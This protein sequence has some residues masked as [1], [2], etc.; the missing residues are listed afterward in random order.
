MQNTTVY[1]HNW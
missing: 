1:T